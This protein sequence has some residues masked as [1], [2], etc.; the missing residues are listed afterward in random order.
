M[1]TRTEVE[2]YF[3]GAEYPA[4]K[5][6]LTILAR[7]KN[8]APDDFIRTLLGMS[9]ITFTGPEEVVQALERLRDPNWTMRD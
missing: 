8:A 2:Q 3:K 4:T 5:H 1:D 7:E 9:D 6:E